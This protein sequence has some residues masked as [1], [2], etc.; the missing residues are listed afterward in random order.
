[1][2]YLRILVIG[3]LLVVP[4]MATADAEGVPDSAVWYFH[5]DLEQMRADGPGQ[6][7]YNWLQDEAL[8]EI[9][10]EAGVDVDNELDSLTAFSLE[11]D[12]PVILF[13]GDISQETKD[14][15]MTFVAAG[16][17]LSPLKSSGKSYYHFA[18]T[19]GDEPLTYSDGDIEIDLESLEDEAWVS[20]D[21]KN[22]I[23]VT[24]SEKQMQ[25]MLASNGKIAG[26]GS[27]NGA[28][29]VL[30]AEKTLL[31]AGMNSA[32]VSDGDS[33]WDSNILRNTEQVAFLMAAAADKLALEAKLI[34]AEPEMAESLASVVRGLVSLMAFSDEM[35]PEAIAMLQGTKVEAKGNSLSIS[36]AI[37]PELVVQTLSE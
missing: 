18:G 26:R 14:K 28:L 21:L 33:D 30:T 36:L 10:A 2:R 31:Q 8:S 22:K 6:G 37:A 4:V 23:L 19:E 13:E 35:D 24:R 12:G 29:L 1:M 34:T 3:L 20:L 27:H 9:K 25:A 5:I 11:G 16:G 17:D 15:V 7:V 32:A